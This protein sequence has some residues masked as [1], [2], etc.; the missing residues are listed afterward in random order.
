MWGPYNP[1]PLRRRVLRGVSTPLLEIDLINLN[2]S[3]IRNKENVDI[4]KLKY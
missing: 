2:A 1:P 4:F 3:V